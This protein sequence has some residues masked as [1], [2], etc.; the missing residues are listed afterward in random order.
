[1]HI[2]KVKYYFP[3]KTICRLQ[4]CPYYL[5]PTSVFRCRL[6]LFF[7]LF[8]SV[9]FVSLAFSSPT[10]L[11]LAAKKYLFVSLIMQPSTAFHYLDILVYDSD[12]VSCSKYMYQIGIWY[13][14]KR[15]H[16]VLEETR[17]L[18]SRHAWF[19]SVWICSGACNSIPHYLHCLVEAWEG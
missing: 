7:G 10:C 19:I 9:W 16:K 12:M 1:M 8:L 18:H 17:P 2:F 13:G 14:P 3:R 4:T 5:F 11:Q 6:A 15:N